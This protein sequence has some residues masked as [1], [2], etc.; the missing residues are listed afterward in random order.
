MAPERDMKTSKTNKPTNTSIELAAHDLRCITDW[1]INCWSLLLFFFICTLDKQMPDQKRDRKLDRT[2]EVH[3]YVA[4][5]RD[6]T[7]YIFATV[8][9]L[10]T[11]M[12]TLQVINEYNTYFR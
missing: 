8:N 7:I 6:I 2:H 11:F 12:T 3:V 4:Q 10:R 1:L 9:F 5:K